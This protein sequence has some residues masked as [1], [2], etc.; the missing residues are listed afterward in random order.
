MPRSQS[1]TFM[2]PPDRMYSA[3]SSHSS[4]VAEMPRLSMTGTL[5][6]SELAQQ[7]EVLHV[8]RADLQDVRVA[9]DQLELADV[10]HLGDEQQVVPVGGA[11]A[12]AA[13]LPRRGPG[14]CRGCC[15]A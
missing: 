10:H 6:V 13:A 12:A 2:L 8:A 9:L 15:A 11:I 4:M 5:R 1:I 3:D 7:R 14:S